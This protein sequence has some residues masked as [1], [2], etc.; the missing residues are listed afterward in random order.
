[1]ATI[2]EEFDLLKL[3]IANGKGGET[4]HI[5][6]HEQERKR[7]HTPSDQTKMQINFGTNESLR[8]AWTETERIRAIIVDVGISQHVIA[9]AYL[10][11]LRSLTTEKLKAMISEGET[12]G[13]K[14]PKAEIPEW[15]K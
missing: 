5:V 7:R 13:P 2:K 10:E 14:P 12:A 15:A 3:K 9:D 6:Y 8:A 1:M 11:T 4:I